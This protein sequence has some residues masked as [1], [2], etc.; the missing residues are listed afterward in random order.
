MNRRDMAAPPPR[1]RRPRRA[2]RVSTRRSALALGRPQD[3]HPRRDDPQVPRRGGRADQQERH[4]RGQVEG[5][6]GG[7]AATVEA[8]VPRHARARSAARRRPTLKRDGLTGTLDRGGVV[9]EE[10][11]VLPRAVRGCTSPGTCTAPRR[12]GLT[13]KHPAD[14]P[15]CAGTSEPRAGREQN[16]VPGPR[17]VVRGQRLRLP[18]GGHAPQLGKVAGKHHGTYNL[19]RWCAQRRGY[20]PARRRVLERHPGHRLPLY[21][22][23]VNP[24]RSGV[25]GISS[26]RATDG[27]GRGGQQPGSRWRCPVSQDERPRKLRHEPGHQRPLRL[28]VRLQLMPVWNGRRFSPCFAPSPCCSRTQGRR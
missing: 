2:P 11:P 18:G 3:I 27:V 4:G 10:G 13:R 6:V 8:T 16:R 17:A 20:T 7:E 28:H 5:G 1:T 24:G 14:P 9:I 12:P 15:P 21:A 25:T 26:G 19:N 23:E 22:T